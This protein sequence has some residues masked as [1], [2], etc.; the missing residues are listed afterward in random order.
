VPLT[1]A[2]GPAAVDAVP[3]LERMMTADP[4]W[5]PRVDYIYALTAIGTP[6]VP[7]L[8][9]VLLDQ[10]QFDAE[11]PWNAS[12][13]AEGLGLLGPTAR[14]A[15]PCLLQGL[16]TSYA[17]IPDLTSRWL[18]D[19]GIN[20]A[21]MMLEIRFNL[22]HAII[23]IRDPDRVVHD[24][25]IAAGKQAPDEMTLIILSWVLGLTYEEPETAILLAPSVLGGTGSEQK[26]IMLN[27]LLDLSAIPGFA[28]KSQGLI[29]MLREIEATGPQ[30][31][32][33]IADRLV[34]SITQ[35]E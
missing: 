21:D 30:D 34:A 14:E 23:R 4:M 15:L 27:V 33:G 32:R 31:L 10:Q 20:D 16:T 19:M 5:M 1:F 13:A 18:G 6:A 26:M 28:A 25:L 2:L 29:P 22:A 3:L 35:P 24:Q 7:A 11:G 17:P 8:C 12:R 9:R